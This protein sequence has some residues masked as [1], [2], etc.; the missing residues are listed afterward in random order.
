MLKIPNS[1]LS[2]QAYDEACVLKE[3]FNGSILV[4]T[5]N[6]EKKLKAQNKIRSAKLLWDSQENGEEN[7]FKKA[8]AD[9]AVIIAQIVMVAKDA[10][11][12]FQKLVGRSVYINGL[13]GKTYWLSADES[14]ELTWIDSS[15]VYG[16]T[17]EENEY[18]DEE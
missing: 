10:P 17:Y 3:I 13:V 12:I 1:R 7:Q 11:E 16:L 4:Y 6:N 8:K 18:D 5:K 9:S 15:A 14:E 2:Q